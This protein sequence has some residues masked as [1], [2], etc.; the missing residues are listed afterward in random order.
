[1]I[2]KQKMLDFVSESHDDAQKIFDI[3]GIV[4]CWVS[5]EG[6]VSGY[7][8][9][10]LGDHVNAYLAAAGMQILKMGMSE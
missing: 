2:D 5:R 9:T 7:S 6:A 4:I 8:L 10:A 3:E 1:M